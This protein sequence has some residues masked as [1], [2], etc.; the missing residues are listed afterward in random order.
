M[1]SSPPSMPKPRKRNHRARYPHARPIAQNC[2]SRAA[3]SPERADS[4]PSNPQK[5]VTHVCV[6]CVSEIL[7]R[8]VALQPLLRSGKRAGM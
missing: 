7:A 1:S 3:T 4:T 6:G 5:T 8:C 2:Q